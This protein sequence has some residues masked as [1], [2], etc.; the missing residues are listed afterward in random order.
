MTFLKQGVVLAMDHKMNF[1][2]NFC[3]L[4]YACDPQPFI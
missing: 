3:D 2:S 1:S 4:A